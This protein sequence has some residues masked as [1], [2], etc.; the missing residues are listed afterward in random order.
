LEP[1]YAAAHVWRGVALY[2]QAQFGWT[3]FAAQALQEAKEAQ[4]RASQ[5]DDRDALPHA[6]LARIYADLDEFELALAEADKALAL[7]P[8]D[9]E[10][11]SQRGRVLLWAGRVDEAIA[12]IEAARVLSPAFDAAQEFY[13]GLAYYSARRYREA[14]AQGEQLLARAPDFPVGPAVLAAAYGQLERL[15]EARAALQLQRSVNPSF[16][17]EALGSRFRDAADREH[18]LDGLRKAGLR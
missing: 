18:L 15:E 11:L 2:L 13:L 8:S 14:A 12:S 7:N 3:E 9:G 5:L 16:A 6:W 1:D 4:L 10:S 17:L